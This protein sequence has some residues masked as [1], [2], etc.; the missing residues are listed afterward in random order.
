MSATSNYN[1]IINLKALSLIMKKTDNIYFID[2]TFNMTRKIS[3]I[4]KKRYF[5]IK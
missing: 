1:T 2:S 3:N 5:I 4:S